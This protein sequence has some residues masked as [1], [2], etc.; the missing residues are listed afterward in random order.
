MKTIQTS[1]IIY[2]IGI[3]S[4]ITLD[5]QQ[6]NPIKSYNGIPIITYVREV[7]SVQSYYYIPPQQYDTIINSGVKFIQV[8]NMNTS[9]YYS[10]LEGKEVF[11]LPEQYFI[12][13][14]TTD[15][16]ITY[17]TEGR[18]SQWPTV[19][20][21]SLDGKATL[22]SLETH[23]EKYGGLL[24]TL[25]TNGTPLSKDTIVYGPQYWQDVYY[26]FHNDQDTI[27]RYK[28]SYKLKLEQLIPSEYLSTD[29]VCILQVTA[30]DTY[31]SVHKVFTTGYPVYV[32]KE[33]A[34][35]IGELLPF[36][37]TKTFEMTYTL[38]NVP[39]SISDQPI[40]GNTFPNWQKNI[41]GTKNLWAAVKN[42]EFR[43]VWKSNS[44]LFRLYMDTIKVYDDRGW[45]IINRSEMQQKIINQVTQAPYKSKAAGWM[46]VDEPVS[47]DQM[48]P[49]RKV[50]ELIESVS[51]NTGLWINYNAGWNGRFGDAADPGYTMSLERIDEFMRR[52]KKAN[53]WVV[54]NPFDWP[55]CPDSI[56]NAIEINLGI[57]DSILSKLAKSGNK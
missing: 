31:D 44:E 42:I 8:E 24:R 55:Y 26:R 13:Q 37:V 54:L 20:T 52:V 35:T 18:Y 15:K 29:T 47:I 23:T 7:D 36:N 56:P 3:F 12:G 4:Q 14:N 48:A 49:I 32:I 9:E 57:I 1:V 27:I 22:K 38:E 51:S 6:Q 28:V 11:I 2:L 25:Q 10:H 39:D 43:I 53:L 17:Y 21:D 46:S 19:G 50:S 40:V 30:K 33:K 41:A 16:Y 34:V 45:E 5:A